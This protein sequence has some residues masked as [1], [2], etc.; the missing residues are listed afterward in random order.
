VTDPNWAEV[1]TAL[2]TVIGAVGL[3]G[4][5]GLAVYTGRMVRESERSRHAA[6]AVDF[7]RRWDEP[8]LVEAR[9]FVGQ[10]RTPEE[11]RTA[12]DGFVASNSVQAFVLY[13]ELDYFEQLGALES[14]G[15]VDF[16]LIKLLLGERLITRWEMWK[17]S[18]EAMGPDSYPMFGALVERMRR[19]VAT[20]NNPI[21]NTAS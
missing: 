1:V 14:L 19:A 13:R 10:F 18:L 21:A 2:A 3:L 17:P 6:T 12:F 8:D 16:E 5:V 7:L 11:L 20:E 4:T 15:A 9:H